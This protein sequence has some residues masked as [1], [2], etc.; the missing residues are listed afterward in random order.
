MTFRVR[1]AAFVV[2]TYA[3]AALV[4]P[5][6]AQQ[7]APNGEWRAHGGDAGHIQYAPLD[8]ITRD[9]IDALEIAWRWTSPDTALREQHEELQEPTTRIFRHEVTPLKIGD[10]L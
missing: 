3:L 1:R 7:G 8:Q 5:A 4:A 2:F 6:R 9:N 10:A